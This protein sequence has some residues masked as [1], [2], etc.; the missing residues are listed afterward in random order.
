MLRRL[1]PFCSVVATLLVVAACSRTGL[2]AS[3]SND[4]G[5]ITRDGS[6]ELTS[7]A[8]SAL[9]DGP[10]DGNLVGPD[11]QLD[12]SVSD[13]EGDVPH[14]S[15][16]DRDS[17]ADQA[18]PPVTGD[19]RDVPHASDLDRDS[20]ADQAVPPVTGD[21]G[22]D[23]HVEL[24]G[25]DDAGRDRVG[26]EASVDQ[27][28]P[29]PCT[30][31]PVL[32]IPPMMLLDGYDQESLAVADLNGDGKLDLVSAGRNVLVLLGKGD[33]KFASGIAH[34]P[35]TAGFAV[36]S[37][38]GDL[39]GDGKADI[40][41]ADSSNTVSV[42]LGNGDGT[43]ATEVE[44]PTGDFPRALA[45]GD[46]NNDGKPDLVTANNASNTVSVLLGKG[47]GTLAPKLDYAS[48]GPSTGVA[49]G[50]LNGDGKL[51]MVMVIDS[52]P[53]TLSA[54]L[55][56][57]D[58]TFAPSIDLPFQTT[59][60]MDG[61]PVALG[62]LNGDGRL[63]LVVAVVY[64]GE[65]AVLLGKG[66]GT[67]AAPMSLSTKGGPGG[68]WLRDLNHDGRLDL[69]TAWGG[70]RV[71]LGR[72]DGSFAPELVHP[73]SASVLAL[74]A[75]DVDGD[76]STDIAVAA[77]DGNRGW[78]DVLFGKG[79]GTF[80][81]GQVLTYQADSPPGSVVLGDLNADGNLD[82]V[83]MSS[84]SVG[85][86]L[87]AGDGSF[88][89][90]SEYP[91]G[92]A[93]RSIGLGDL[94]GDGAIDIVTVSSTTSSVG[95]L[96]GQGDAQ[97]APKLDYPTDQGPLGVTVGDLNADGVLDVVTSNQGS[98]FKGTVSVLLGV[99]AGRLATHVDYPV[100][101]NPFAVALGDLNG[102][103]KLDMAVANM[104][105][106][107]QWSISVLLAKGDGTFA[108]QS[109]Y[110]CGFGPNSI[111]LGD[112]NGD[113]KLDI[114][115]A[116]STA[117]TTVSVLLGNGDG[118]FATYVEYTTGARP[119]SVVLG[120]LDRDGKLDIVTANPDSGTLSLLLG[121][122]D[123]T[124]ASAIDYAF[125]ANTV[126]L[127]DINGDGRLDVVTDRAVLLGSCW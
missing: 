36:A 50:D 112:L 11:T 94:N 5:A 28:N 14:A 31:A 101:V 66:D 25:Q 75:A 33:R 52:S 80:A 61:A 43:F 15:D 40:V 58:G 54:A 53:L 30:G 2:H 56:N 108:P 107:G 12:S 68:L 115:T 51:D 69:V 22:D 62:D 125:A 90:I 64:N 121:K 48:K 92:I 84:T 124:F 95:V 81:S 118:T 39:N 42:L 67:F 100:G 119:H 70:V 111:A 116:N 32:G 93:T 41:L 26:R 10:S 13:R 127:G 114:V 106:D 9:R 49:L 8:A 91:T 97:F 27:D 72:G 3:H 19:A 20:A 24:D 87:G 35:A 73:F 123:G 55:G 71:S 78:V 89:A 76:G 120:D 6:S 103:R 59:M 46:L 126:A 105:V 16:L 7:D 99:G 34:A 104:G 83:G 88:A 17:A 65:V 102:D 77:S 98:S 113:G 79:D 96:L 122:G 21:G 85:V 37:V 74:A 60:G 29:S 44:Y 63:D 117:A 109:A 38:L 18:V 110:A 57:G 4:G 47:D 23:R 45:I 82:L 86:L 1:V